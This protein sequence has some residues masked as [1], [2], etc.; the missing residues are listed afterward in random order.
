MMTFDIAIDRLC[1]A[2]T[3]DAERYYAKYSYIK[4]VAFK[5]CG[6]KKYIRIKSFENVSKDMEATTFKGGRIHCFVNSETG[7]IY[8]PATWKAPYLRG[9][10]YVRGNIFKPETYKDTDPHG[11]W[12]YD[13]SSRNT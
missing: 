13:R 8:K 6:G 3:R 9:R 11:G 2:L 12:L 7:D 10:N 5:P 1:N 4:S